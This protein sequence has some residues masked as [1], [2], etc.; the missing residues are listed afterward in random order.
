M[1]SVFWSV[2]RLPHYLFPS[3]EK[4]SA[5]R[6]RMHF[7]FLVSLTL[8]HRLTRRWR[9]SQVVSMRSLNETHCWM[10]LR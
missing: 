8:Q 5:V 9:Q 4:L 6:F 3:A 10:L 2:W 7:L 1:G